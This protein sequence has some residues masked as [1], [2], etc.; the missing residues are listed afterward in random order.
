MKDEVTT[1]SQ[2][3][4]NHKREDLMKMKMKFKY[5]TKTEQLR[6]DCFYY[7]YYGGVC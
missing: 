5:S 7:T 1:N 2:H 6:I 4:S 3:L